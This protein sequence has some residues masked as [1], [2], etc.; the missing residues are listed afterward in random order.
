MLK[1]PTSRQRMFNVLIFITCM[2]NYIYDKEICP[3]YNKLY[4]ISFK[5]LATAISM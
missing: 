4:N 2:S 3:Q 5:L 1:K